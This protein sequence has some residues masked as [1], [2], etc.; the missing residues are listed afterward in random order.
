M[1]PRAGSSAAFNFPGARPTVDRFTSNMLQK[2]QTRTMDTQEADRNNRDPDQV[3]DNPRLASRSETFY[4][5]EDLKIIKR[6]FVLAIGDDDI[7]GNA[8]QVVISMNIFDEP[9]M[10]KNIEVRAK[11]SNLIIETCPEILKS[12][13]QLIPE[14]KAMFRFKDLRPNKSNSARRIELFAPLHIIAERML[15]SARQASD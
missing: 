15:V 14:F 5:D 4:D 9:D 3:M 1:S 13:T 2:K 8:F 12:F 6:C 10:Q 11:L 7:T